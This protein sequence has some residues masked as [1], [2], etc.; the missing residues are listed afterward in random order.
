MVMSELSV[1]G[2]PG[3]HPPVRGWKKRSRVRSWVKEQPGVELQ[4]V[5]GYS[6][7][8]VPAVVV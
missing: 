5:Q 7:G 1:V 6:R 8:T 3:G 2:R 4:L